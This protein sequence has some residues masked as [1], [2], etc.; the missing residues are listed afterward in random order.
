MAEGS[1]AAAACGQHSL[2]IQRLLNAPRELVFAAFSEARH[3][4]N[5]LGPHGF[6]APAVELDFR[7]GGRFRACIRSAEGADIWMQGSYQEIV[8]PKRIVYSFAWENETGQ[9]GLETVIT[10]D[11]AERD[12]RTELIFQQSSFLSAESRDSHE[13]GWSECFERL[14]EYLLS[15]QAEGAAARRQ[16]PGI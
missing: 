7:V 14:A 13:S 5:W 15:L 4:L 9:P 8:P 3:Q 2:R 16:L 10:V 12:G 6:S 1:T 11:L